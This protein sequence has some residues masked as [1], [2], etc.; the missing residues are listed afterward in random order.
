MTAADDLVERAES[1][2]REG[3]MDIIGRRLGIDP[4]ELR[5]RNVLHRSEL[6]YASPGGL[7]FDAVSPNFPSASYAHCSFAA[8]M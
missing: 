5:R 7:T 4:I 1:V 2:A 8:S 6:P 3:M